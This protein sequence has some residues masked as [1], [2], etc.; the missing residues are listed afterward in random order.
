MT[1]GS[2]YDENGHLEATEEKP[3]REGPIRVVVVD[4]QP[5]FTEMLR[6]VLDMQ[7]DIKVV[8]MAFTG[9]EGLSMALETKPDVLLVD[10]HMPGL[11]GLEVIK[12]LRSAGENTTV[13]VLTADTGEAVMAEA[14]AAGAAGYITKQQALSEVVQ[15]VRTASEGEPVVPPFMIP[16]ILSHFHRQQQREQQAEILRSRLSAREIEILE[17]LARGRSNEAISEIFVL[18][19]N[20]VRT[21]IQN[22]IKKMGVH[23]KLEATTLALQL[24][25]ITMPRD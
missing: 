13:V 22:I 7:T 8:G 20:T 14:I 3:P 9:D 15:A 18:S 12:G 24:G 2:Q 10:Y 19:P 17:Q 25:I 6:V 11:T 23:S 16:R 5:V 4:D 21:H 1:N